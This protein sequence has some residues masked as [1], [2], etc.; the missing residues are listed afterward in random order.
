MDN[1][2][3]ASG[4]TNTGPSDEWM[5]KLNTV[6]DQISR[7]FDE[8]GFQVLIIVP[9]GYGRALESMQNQIRMKSEGSDAETVSANP[10][11][12]ILVIRN[13]ADDKSAMAFSSVRDALHSW[14]AAG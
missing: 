5:V 8:G 11:P 2:S 7:Q 10:V 9:E 6:Q 12:T 4:E 13:S 1:F 3:A 14:E